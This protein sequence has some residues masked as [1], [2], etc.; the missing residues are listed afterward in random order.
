M[1][2]YAR[3]GTRMAL[4]ALL[5]AALLPAL[6]ARAA[7][8]DAV[9]G[10]WHSTFTIYG[11]LPG[12]SADLRFK[13]PN[14]DATTKTD[15]N[16]LE[17]LSG[18][19]MVQ[20]AVRN[21]EWGFFGDLDWV[22]FD[23]EKG[24]FTSIGGEHVGADLNLDT[25][26]N[27]KGGMLT[28]GG[29]Y[30]IGHGQWGFTD[31]VFGGRYLWIKGNLSWDFSATGAGGNFGIA[32]SGHLSRQTHVSDA[33][34][35]L[36]GRWDIGDGRWFVPYYI[37]A[38]TGDSDFTGQAIVGIGYSYDWGGISLVWRHMQYS[39]GNATD[40]LRRVAFDGPAFALTWH[41]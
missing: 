2:V 25:R 7:E 19:L 17:N 21:G 38:G 26:W 24:R 3:L 1:G 5:A 14:G 36:R 10:N 32:D 29:L 4:I 6:P 15:N 40:L 20:A 35:G 41:F 37:D 16:V 27:L 28:L 30:N 12:V 33:V 13:L 11:W 23:N 8:G 31:L 22:K 9:D 34:I 18:A 39:Q